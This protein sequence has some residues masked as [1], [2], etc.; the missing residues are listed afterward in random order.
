MAYKQKTS[1]NAENIEPKEKK[2]PLLSLKKQKKSRSAVTP[3][4]QLA[5][6]SSYA[7][8]KNLA[9]SSRWALNDWH[10]E[11]N[12]RNP[13]K[14]CPEQLLLSTCTKDEWLSVYITETRNHQ[15]ERYPPKT[16]PALLYGI[17]HEMKAR[18]PEYP[19]FLKKGDS[20]FT[21]F[22]NT[23]DNLFKMLRKDGIGADISATEGEEEDQL[24]KS[25]V[26]NENTPTGQYFITVENVFV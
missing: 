5:S 22:Q 1:D 19:N 13:T 18:N 17:F 2:R 16:I 20:D 23:L 24:W 6:M 3:E 4:D 21:K 26:L 15:G 25:G 12:A 11:Y 14:Q 10:E 8:P 7:M 9:I